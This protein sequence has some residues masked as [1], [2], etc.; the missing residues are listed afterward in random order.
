V[1]WLNTWWLLVALVALGMAAAALEAT[2]PQW[3]ESFRVRIPLQRH[4]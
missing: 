2:A 3:L 1:G 4:R